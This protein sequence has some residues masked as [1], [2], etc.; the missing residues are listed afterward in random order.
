ML[1]L[2]LSENCLFFFFFWC[3]EKFKPVGRVFLSQKRKIQQRMSKK[4]KKKPAHIPGH[5]KFKPKRRD[6]VS[7]NIFKF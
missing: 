7:Q 5:K 1:G 6:K 3:G 4:K 2:R